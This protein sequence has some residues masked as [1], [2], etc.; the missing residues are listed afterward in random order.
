MSRG[1][2]VLA[3]LAG[4]LLGAAVGYGLD[5]LLAAQGYWLVIGLVG[6]YAALLWLVARTT[7]A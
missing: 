3:L 6:F 2:G 5:R 4:T 7:A 1:Q